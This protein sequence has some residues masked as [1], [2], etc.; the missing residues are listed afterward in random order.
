MTKVLILLAG[1]GSRLGNLT[2]NNHKA[3]LKINKFSFLDFQINIFDKQKIQD[4]TFLLGHQKKLFNKFNFKKI[5]NTN[6]KK[7]N[8][9]YTL[10]LAKK[11]IKNCKSDLII[12]YGD[13]IYSKKVLNKLIKSKKNYNIVIDKQWKKL[14]RRRFKD[15][16]EDA[17]TCVI[18]KG[19]IIELGQKSTNIKKFNGQY[20]GLVKIKK[21]KIND[22][23]KF[24][25]AF[26][27]NK[28][29]K[30]KFMT[31]FLTYLIS[32]KIK[33][34]PIFINQEWLELDTLKD[35]KLYKKK[36]T[37]NKLKLI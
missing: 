15:I 18:K 10:F 35:Y 9:V 2:T 7:T 30:K 37:F 5:I 27:K 36:K 29:F 1:K 31:D 21:N 23:Y 14:W 24:L 20:S 16:Y 13:I 12:S 32:N 8:M 19:Q 33:L 3:L 34:T 28:N 6:F 11:F 26:S 4:I 17:E 25:M 22:F